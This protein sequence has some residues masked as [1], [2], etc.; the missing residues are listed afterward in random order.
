MT[1]FHRVMVASLVAGMKLTCYVHM[2]PLCRLVLLCYTF[3]LYAL[4]IRLIRF[5]ERS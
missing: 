4:E 3:D 2:L 5:M 1:S